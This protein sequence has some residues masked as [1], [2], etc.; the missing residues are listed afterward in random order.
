VNEGTTVLTLLLLLCDAAPPPN[1]SSRWESAVR[2]I[3]KR[4]AKTPPP[5][6]AVFFCGSS[7]IVRWDLPK[8]FP[9]LRTVNRGFGGSKIADSTFFAHRLVLPHNPS[10]I[11]FYAGDNDL[12]GGLTPER[13][14][15]DFR[16]FV[17]RVRTK[18]PDVP[19][20][21]IAIKPSIARWKSWDRIQKANALIRA[22][23]DGKLV[24]FIDVAA[25]MLGDDG[26]PRR[27]LFVKDGLHLSPAGYAIWNA[28][29]LKAL[30]DSKARP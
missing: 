15:D 18:L 4:D 27:E 20:H 6:G 30:T 16:A 25:P 22:D 8:S 1:S 29:V 28:L 9:T 26:T 11:V 23:C 12:G 21:F 2:A 19:I 14:R 17:A 7:S 13:V 3:E 5:G 24:T 10:A